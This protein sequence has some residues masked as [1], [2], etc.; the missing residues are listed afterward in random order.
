MR[1][2]AEMVS[3]FDGLSKQ[4]N[5]TRAIEPAAVATS[6]HAQLEHF[7]P[8]LPLISALSS[9]FLADDDWEKISSVLGFAITPESITNLANFQVSNVS[10]ESLG[11]PKILSVCRVSCRSC[12][13]HHRNRSLF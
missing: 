9:K 1:E 4:L 12:G 5:K 7:S 13:T 10:F 11:F 6:I 3:V 2:H 8:N